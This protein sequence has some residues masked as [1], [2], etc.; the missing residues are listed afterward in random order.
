MTTFERFERSIPEL[1]TELAPARVP[2]YFD[3]MLQLT[4]GAT[5][6]PAWSFPER[7]LPVD[8]AARPLV[9]RS[10]PWRPLAILALIALL[11]AAGLAAYVGSQNRVPPPFGLAGNGVLMYRDADGSIVS[12]DPKAGTQPTAL[13]LSDAGRDPMLSRDVRRVALFEDTPGLTT[14]VVEGI[15][16][17]GRLSLPGTYRFI[18]ASDWSPDDSKIA[19]IADEDGVASVHIASA[20]GSS[21]I[22]LPLRRNVT[23]MRFL[24]DGRL[25]L[26][27][28]EQP[29]QA[30]PGNPVTD[31]CALFVVG[32][33]GSGF[34]P[35]IPAADFHGINTLSPSVDGK[36]LVY[37]E[38]RTGAEGRLHV[39]DLATRVD[40]RVPD[41]GFPT[42]YSMNR[43][44]LSPDDRSILFDFFEVDGDHWAVVPVT[45]G[46]P[47]RIGPK[48]PGGM[49]AAW[50][51][52]GKA[53]LARYATSDTTS[54]LWLLDPTGSGNDRKL[55]VNVP[56]LPEWQRVAP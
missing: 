27:A 30:C 34:E 43:A 49:D 33:D 15:D 17:S 31:R 12:L 44:Y 3:D 56:Y 45:G 54:E 41:D 39:F 35:L 28:A 32:A 10:F 29:G 22:A 20:D 26:I 50:S 5:Q 9:A 21:V 16:G 14:I 40:R 8:I 55:D 53:V 4:E 24:P 7:W 23:Y 36:L 48:S 38:W 13:P 6:R 2:D 37:V 19:F 42:L 11:V 47:V 46:T 51:P 1:M 25:V 18:G 52:D